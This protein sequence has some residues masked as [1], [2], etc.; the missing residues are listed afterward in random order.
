M[1]TFKKVSLALLP[2]VLLGL[3][4]GGV[5]CARNRSQESGPTVVLLTDFGTVGY[6]VPQLKGNIFSKY[7]D[8]KVV[9]ITHELPAFDVPTGAYEL[10]VAANEFPSGF[11]FVAVVA[12]GDSTTNQRFLVATSNKDQVFVVPD[13][14][15]ITYIARETGLKSVYQV[16]QQLLTGRMEDLS[17]T[18]VLGQAGGLVASGI[19][20]EQFGPAVT[21]AKMLDIQAPRI[22]GNKLTGAIVFVDNFGNS[23]TNISREM[24]QSFGLKKGDTVVVSAGG[25]SVTA[26]FGNIYSDVPKGDPIVFVNSLQ[27]VELSIN[28]GNFAGTH[29][30]KAGAGI[31]IARK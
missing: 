17:V 1:S 10:S 23:P 24:A 5:G 26:M 19:K 21:D 11:V 28:I 22:Q 9:D 15:L 16:G 25:K 29:G 12:P 30:L 6:R 31:E 2:L 27:V 13:N 8:A 7:P 18:K 3:L 14:G 4:V 20:L